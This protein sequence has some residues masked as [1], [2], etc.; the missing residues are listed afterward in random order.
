MIIYKLL[1]PL[2]QALSPTLTN[3][4]IQSSRALNPF[5]ILEDFIG[6]ANPHEFHLSDCSKFYCFQSEAGLQIALPEQSSGPSG[7]E[8]TLLSID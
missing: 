6:L 4:S 7:F 2:L 1:K 3:R 5:E 8:A